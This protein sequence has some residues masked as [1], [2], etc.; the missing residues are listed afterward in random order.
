MASTPTWDWS[1]LDEPSTS[2]TTPPES[3]F[4]HRKPQAAPTEAAGD[5]Q[6]EPPPNPNRGQRRYGTRQCRICLETVHPTFPEPSESRFSIPTSSKPTYFSEDPDLGR[7]LSPCK[8]KGSQKYVHEGCL[9][10]WRLSNPSAAR[11]YWQCPTCKFTYRM[12]RLHWATVISS[13]VAQAV[14]TVLILIL[15][16]FL[17]GFV[18]DPIIDMYM[19]PIGTIS[20]TV[21]SVITDPDAQ[22]ALPLLEPTTWAERFMKGFVSLGFVGLVKVFLANPFWHWSTVRNSGLAM[23]R[24][25]GGG[26]DRMDNMTI[27]F[28]LIGLFTF[29]VGIW[30]F[31]RTFSRRVLKSVSDR[32][33]DIGGDDDDDDVP[34]Q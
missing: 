11:N 6:P 16:I 22:D 13:K 27:L 15:C 17:L 9:N 28:I 21:S 12:A 3:E 31:V 14:L 1:N 30:K 7:L 19:D 4:R 34:E 20:D 8:C 23:G 32:V 18:A 5:A 24:R 33:L 25:G 10:A 2:Q 29:V 26:R